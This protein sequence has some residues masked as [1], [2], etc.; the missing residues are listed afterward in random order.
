VAAFACGGGGGNG[1]G[2]AAG[3]SGPVAEEALERAVWRDGEHQRI[4]TAHA[5]LGLDI[6]ASHHSKKAGAGV[7]ARGWGE[8]DPVTGALRAA[9]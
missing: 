5:L 7:V 8:A 1:G 2:G 6:G 4:A 3:G 9:M